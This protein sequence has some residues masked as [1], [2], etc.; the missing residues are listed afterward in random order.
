MG[1]VFVM[2][3]PLAN[4]VLLNFRNKNNKDE[5]N[6]TFSEASTSI[7]VLGGTGS[8]KSTAVLMPALYRLIQKGCAG[9]VMDAKCELTRF[10]QELVESD[11]LMLI[12]GS[13]E[14]VPVNII[15]GIPEEVFRALITNIALNQ[16]GRGNRYW[17]QGA[18]RDSMLA[19]HYFNEAK[20]RTITLAELYDIIK[21]PNE[22]CEEV[23]KWL[24]NAPS[25]SKTLLRAIKEVESSP[26]S[27]T[28]LCGIYFSDKEKA[29]ARDVTV[30]E[31][32]AW[33]TSQ[34]ISALSPFANN[35]LLREKLSASDSPLFS[36]H[37][38][39]G[40][41]IA[42]DAPSSIYGEAAYTVCRLV[43]DRFY[44]TLQN[45]SVKYLKH[46]KFGKERFTF[47]LIDEYQN[48]M[49]LS[50][51]AASDG[52]VDDNSWFAQ[53]RSMGH[54]NLIAT[55]GLSS[56]YSSDPSRHLVNSLLQNV[57]TKVFLSTSDMET[58]HYATGI[59]EDG[60][61]LI[62]SL[63]TSKEMGDIMIH[64]GSGFDACHQFSKTGNSK[65]PFMNQFI[66]K[67]LLESST[68]HF[69]P[70]IIDN[71]YY[72]APLV[73]VEEMTFEIPTYNDVNDTD[74]SR[75]ASQGILSLLTPI[76]RDE[77][78]TK[79]EQKNNDLESLLTL[80][81]HMDDGYILI[82][83]DKPNIEKCV[84]NFDDK[85]EEDVK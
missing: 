53:S 40:G 25:L 31:Q 77:S 84:S 39:K 17:G 21:D 43:R 59:L 22:F 62:P 78:A 51:S 27:M 38:D 34:I 82:H 85:A 61:L 29:E 46:N 67:D 54:I 71:P 5:V 32:Y 44:N 50:S 73:V 83:H 72:E 74:D 36:E 75:H 7:A 18:I 12:G 19:Y 47:M 55:Q 76:K 28:A 42:V 57:R 24:R 49:R 20:N 6:V 3:K 81:N 56:L 16:D 41:I 64:K 23:S 48:I 37:L 2:D 69:E 65:M 11:K 13:N 30:S 70:E 4:E 15:G 80:K 79:N 10:C 14:C 63:A 33:H 8:G 68:Y 58:L 35:R 66:G 1:D 26:F 45:R 52:I 9:L 60:H